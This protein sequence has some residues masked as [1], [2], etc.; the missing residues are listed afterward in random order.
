MRTLARALLLCVAVRCLGADLVLNKVI[1]EVVLKDGR[2]L[3]NVTFVA[4]GSDTAMARWDGG[5]GTIR[6]DQLPGI[7]LGAPQDAARAPVPAPSASVA[8]PFK[9]GE[10]PSPETLADR[11]LAAEGGPA[12][13]ALR[14]I[15]FQGE[16]GPVGE[17][18]PIVFVAS[19]PN[20][21]RVEILLAQGRYI[22][23]N[24]PGGH[25]SA[26]QKTGGVAVR[27]KPREG[28]PAARTDWGDSFTEPIWR[29]RELNARL[30]VIG[31]E[32]VTMQNS[33]TSV[34]TFVVS[35][36]APGGLRWDYLIPAD[37]AT[38]PYL[39]KRTYDGDR[40]VETERRSRF[41]R[42]GA[43]NLAM[44]VEEDYGD[45][46]LVDLRFFRVKLDPSLDPGTFA[47]PAL[48]G[49]KGAQL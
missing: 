10:A 21:H 24:G 35:V 6:L 15:R 31:E 36:T 39:A 11:C 38:M 30:E 40:I 3:K 7:L 13:L 46:H 43:L 25:W 23:G 5:R 14:S 44:Q 45:G 27:A 37:D 29:R 16:M 12:L 41:R 18:T 47:S 22:E 4:Q 33:T 1:P 34:R 2:V 48:A 17:G 28:L 42:V 26:A 32:L 49:E 9:R 20:F 8:V 19:Q